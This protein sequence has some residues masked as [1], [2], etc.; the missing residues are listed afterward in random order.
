MRR[1]LKMPFELAGV[2]IEREDAIGVE[3][4]AR[5]NGA[6]EIRGR[7]AGAPLQSVE[8][9]VIGAGHPGGAAAVFI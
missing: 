1:E 5:T 4:V 8:P 6:V 2:G 3:V 7:I 9:R